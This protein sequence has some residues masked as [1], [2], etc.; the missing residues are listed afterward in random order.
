MSKHLKEGGELTV[1]SVARFLA[2]C[3]EVEMKPQAGVSVEE[4]VAALIP[5]RSSTFCVG[6]PH[7]ASFY[8]LSKIRRTLKKK[9]GPKIF[10]VGDIGC[11]SL[12]IYPPYEIGDAKYS[13]GSS[14]AV[15]QGLSE[16]AEEK[17]LAVMGDGTFFHSGIPGLL[18]GVYNK[19]DITFLVLDN[20]V[21]GMTG[22]QPNPG[23]GIKATGE[24]GGQICIEDLIRGCGVEF[25][26]IAES[27]QIQQLEE[28]LTR[29]LGFPGL[30]VVISR[31]LCAMEKRRLLRAE[32]V[33]AEKYA[34]DEESCKQC[35]TCLRRFSCPAIFL[36]D[37]QPVIDEEACLGCS[38]CAQVCPTG[39]ILTG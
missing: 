21:I 1:E 38:V 18:N 5:P 28:K 15:A 4:E 14:L 23:S 26:E 16:F 20:S 8:V 30:A 9:K 35:L 31:G 25:L 6:C 39:A 11:Y 29:A 10:F 3:L 17:I 22:I 12:G 32:G 13:M 36:R 7:S 33:D 24:Q 2:E 34:I 27:F 37:D 19:C